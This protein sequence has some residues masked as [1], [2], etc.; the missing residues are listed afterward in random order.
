MEPTDV[1]LI[2]AVVAGRPECFEPLIS[3]YQSRVFRLVRRYARR[4][5]D[6][7]DLVQEVFVRAYQRLGT[8]RGTAP[9]EHWL[10]RLAVRV[11]YDYLRALQRRR[12]IPW[13]DL[14]DV[15]QQ[16]L[17]RFVADPRTTGETD[18][19]ARELAHKLLSMMSP[20]SRLVLTLQEIEERPVKEIASMTGW[21]VSLVKVRAFRARR[22]MRRL[23]EK[24]T[25]NNQ[26]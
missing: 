9:F 6:V 2:A 12:E 4:E 21:S 16:W 20:A 26:L 3:R 7:E 24:L 15:E 11:C 23:L 13:A 19:G 10:M 1:D 5:S 25:R 22:E 18:A 8:F 14:A 17:E